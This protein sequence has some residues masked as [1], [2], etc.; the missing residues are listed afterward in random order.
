MFGRVGGAT[1]G[2]LQGDSGP[3]AHGS[4][5]RGLWRTRQCKKLNPAWLDSA[6][7]PVASPW[8]RTY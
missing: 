1:V 5:P 7:A 2:V 6:P 4:L 3:N 8:P